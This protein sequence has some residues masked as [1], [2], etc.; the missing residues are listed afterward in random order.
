MLTENLW[1]AKGLVNGAIGTV[2]DFAW[3]EGTAASDLRKVATTVLLVH[4]DSYTGSPVEELVEATLATHMAQHFSSREQARLHLN[5]IIPIFRSRRVF[6]YKCRLCTRTQFP[7]T[8]AYAI[9]VHKSQGCTL[10]KAVTDIS[11]KD[12]I[13]H[14]DDDEEHRD[15]GSEDIYDDA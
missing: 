1:T 8:V 6:I 10:D 7:L 5:K 14:D 11:G 12:W 2:V 4:F 13:D 15:A 3:K 9:T